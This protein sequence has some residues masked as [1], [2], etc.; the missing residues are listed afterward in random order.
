MP[1][2][3]HFYLSFIVAIAIGWI[4][5]FLH[6]LR[7]DKSFSTPEVKFFE[8]YRQTFSVGRVATPSWVSIRKRL[9]QRLEGYALLKGVSCEGVPQNG[10][11]K[12][13]LTST[14]HEV[15]LGTL[16]KIE[17]KN[18]ALISLAAILVALIALISTLNKSINFQLFLVVVAILMVVPVWQLFRGIR[19]ID[20][21]DFEICCRDEVAIRCIS[22]Q[23]QLAL[24]DDL[25]CKE[26]AFRFAKFWISLLALLV[27]LL[28]VCAITSRVS[29]ELSNP[30]G[31]LY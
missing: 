31:L 27:L 8:V 25:L 24:I 16:K 28:L 3:S 12:R 18:V 11:Q 1:E 14:G 13:P 10:D 9:I 22:V 15:L 26:R 17:A 6:L 19:Q 5:Q 20:Q 2:S 4:F 21:H 23:L 7:L 30:S 29:L